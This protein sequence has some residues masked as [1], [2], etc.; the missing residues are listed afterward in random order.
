MAVKKFQGGVDVVSLGANDPT[1]IR[2]NVK[3]YTQDGVVW[4]GENNDQFQYLLDMYVNS[5]THNA[6]CNAIIKQIYGKGLNFPDAIDEGTRKQTTYTNQLG[7]YTN[8]K[9][10]LVIDAE[11]VN[12]TFYYV[13]VYQGSYEIAKFKV[14]ATTQTDLPKY[15]ITQGQFTEAPQG[16]NDFIVL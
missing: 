5:P 1:L 15:E 3:Q 16:S 4:Y 11:T 8:D 2:Q 12:D 7:T 10:R 13:I 9:S 6:V 14:F